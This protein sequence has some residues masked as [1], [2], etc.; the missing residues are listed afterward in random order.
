MPRIRGRV[1]RRPCRRGA[2]DKAH[3]SA[4]GHGHDELFLRLRGQGRRRGPIDQGARV[5]LPLLTPTLV[6]K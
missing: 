5:A 4:M 2:V 3:L 6:E 1:R